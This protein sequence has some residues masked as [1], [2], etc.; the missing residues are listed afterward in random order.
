MSVIFEFGKHN[1]TAKDRKKICDCWPGFMLPGVK[2]QSCKWE[3][4]HLA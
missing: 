4:R 1:I 3:D 2:P